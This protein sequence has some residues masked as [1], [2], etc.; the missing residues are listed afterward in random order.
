MWQGIATLYADKPWAASAV[1]AA[2]SALAAAEQ[3]SAQDE[4][5]AKKTAENR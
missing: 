5:V 1:A 3:S 2:K 4:D